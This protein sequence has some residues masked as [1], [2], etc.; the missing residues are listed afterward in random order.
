MKRINTIMIGE[1]EAQTEA[2]TQQTQ[3]VDITQIP[4][5]EVEITM[6]NLYALR[7]SV[8]DNPA[9]ADDPFIKEQLA[10][11]AQLEKHLNEAGQQQQQGK[12]AGEEGNNPD[13]GD[14]SNA[15]GND[16][17]TDSVDTTN[18]FF[19]AESPAAVDY[20]KVNTKNFADV[21]KKLGLDPT[22]ESYLGELLKGYT[23]RANA[24]AELENTKSEAEKLR[25]TIESLPKDIVQMINLWSN[26]KPYT[27]V[28][29]ISS[30]D[31]T[32]EFAKLTTDE[33]IKMHNYYFS[34]DKLDG[35]VDVSDKAVAKALKAT[36]ARYNADKI[37]AE[38]GVKAEKERREADVRNF[39]A[40][41]DAS[42][43]AFQTAYPKFSKTEFAAVQNIV[44]KDGILP[45]FLDENGNYKPEAAELIAF[46]LYGKTLLSNAVAATKSKTASSTKA[47]VL[48]ATNSQGGGS[49]G[50]S[51]KNLNDDEKEAQEF[52]RSSQTNFTY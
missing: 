45:L 16:D 46:A 31:L 17:S 33:K 47:E 8:A 10:I 51:T 20:S 14:K 39:Q 29:D 7:E 37:T 24:Q 22:K 52:L 41:A 4:P 15:G 26:G 12:D 13:K 32:K 42:L 23:E 35:S 44:K 48:A 49:G 18:V 5:D 36:E 50:N 1:G 2:G 19:G 27:S 3:N 11:G 30:V 28:G 38:A 34:D 9:L 21:A 6:A 40:S 43:K 25:S